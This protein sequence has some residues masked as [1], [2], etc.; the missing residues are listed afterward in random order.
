VLAK[1]TL[2]AILEDRS[3]FGLGG[4]FFGVYP[5]QVTSVTDPDGQ[6]RVKVA[7]PWSPDSGGAKYE[8]WAR[9]ATMMAGGNRGSFF[10]PD[11]NDEVLVAFEAG[12]TRRPYVLGALWNGQDSPPTS[13]DSAGSNNT[14]LL[15]SRNGV[16]ITLDDTSGS[17]KLVVETP[18][19]QKIT[20][21]DGAGTVTIQDSRGNEVQT[22]PSGV[23]VT[24][25]AAVTIHAATQIELTATSVTVNAAMTTFSGA[26][27]GSV[28]VMTPSVLG[29]TYT[30]GLGNIL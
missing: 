12:D 14:K 16:K 28:S 25:N 9:L 21:Q 5:A 8:A 30:P 23:T 19:G 1:S 3:P 26:V 4:R 18:G 7:L 22:G 20:L 13:M 24:S 6:A 11:V 15:C 29:A 27:N 2:E 10:V 17:E